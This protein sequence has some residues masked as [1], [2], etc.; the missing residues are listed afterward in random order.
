MV[1]GYIVDT[2]NCRILQEMFHDANGDSETSLL[3]TSRVCK[4]EKYIMLLIRSSLVDLTFFRMNIMPDLPSGWEERTSIV[5]SR[6]TPYYVNQFT[7]EKQWDKPTKPAI[8]PSLVGNTF[9]SM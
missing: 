9:P 6:G 8:D 7:K 3:L 2:D 1:V 5:E 4:F